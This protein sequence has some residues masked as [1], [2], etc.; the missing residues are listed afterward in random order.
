MLPL[1][2]GAHSVLATP[3]PIG[4]RPPIVAVRRNAST[5]DKL[6]FGCGPACCAA[7]VK[8]HNARITADRTTVAIGLLM[9][10]FCLYLTKARKLFQTDHCSSKKQAGVVKG[11]ANVIC[12]GANVFGRNHKIGNEDRNHAG[13]VRGPDAGTGILKDNAL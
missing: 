10:F 8:L 7:A 4:W 1:S 2:I 13:C 11:I 6:S 5:S 3:T 9:E 12:Q